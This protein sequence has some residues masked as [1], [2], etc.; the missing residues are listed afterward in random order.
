MSPF[1]KI[2]ALHLSRNS[3]TVCI[4]LSFVPHVAAASNTMPGVKLLIKEGQQDAVVG[5][6]FLICMFV[7]DPPSLPSDPSFRNPGTI[8]G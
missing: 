8:P 6:H 3:T 2:P 7:Q 5:A 1:F 4:L